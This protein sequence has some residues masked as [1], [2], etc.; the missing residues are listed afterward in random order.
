MT[1]VNCSSEMT[2]EMRSATDVPDSREVEVLRRGEDDTG[3]LQARRAQAIAAGTLV[4]V[5]R[6]KPIT[7]VSRGLPGEVT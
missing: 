4:A 2:G 6:C 1:Q 7:T 3:G 5:M